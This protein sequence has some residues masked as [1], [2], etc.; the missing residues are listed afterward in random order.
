M[1]DWLE[2][3]KLVRRLTLLWATSLITYVVYNVVDDLS[4]MTS[5]G[6]SVVVAIIGILTTVIGFYQYSRGKDDNHLN[7]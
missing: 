3:H 7:H 4:T 2:K 5:A 6:A 1:K